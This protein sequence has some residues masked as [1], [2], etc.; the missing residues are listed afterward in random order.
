[1]KVSTPLQI[2]EQLYFEPSKPSLEKSVAS[3]EVIPQIHAVVT[4]DQWSHHQGRNDKP[5]KTVDD[6][7]R[8]LTNPA[9]NNPIGVLY[10]WGLE[11]SQ[12]WRL[13]RARHYR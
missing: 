10:D 7:G 3:K 13:A 2:A 1:M 12:I 8:A 5:R 4:L 9:V 6:K 11:V